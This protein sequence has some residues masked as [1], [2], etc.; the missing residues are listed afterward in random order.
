MGGFFKEKTAEALSL[1]NRGPLEFDSGKIKAEILEKYWDLGFYV[2]ENV[3]DAGEMQELREEFHKLLEKAPSGSASD[4]DSCGRPLE[5]DDEQ[6]RMF[7]FVKPLSD[8]YGGSDITG[9]RYQVKLTEPKPPEDAPD[10]VLLQIGG[11]LQF[12]D[13]CVRIYGHPGLLSMAAAVNGDDFTPFTEV[14][15][16]KQPRI[17]AAVSWHQDGT[18]HWDNPDLDAGTHGFNYMLNLYETVAENSLW[19]VPGSHKDGKADIKSMLANSS[20]EHLDGA[21]PLLC[22]PGDVAIVS[23]QIVH[24]SFPNQS[25]QPRYTFV[26]GFHRRSSVRNIQAWQREPY[27]D[28]YLDRTSRL[29]PLAVDARKENQPEEEPFRYLPLDDEEQIRWE[30][31]ERDKILKHYHKRMIGI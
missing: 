20:S 21:L 29:I 4:H 2:F 3:I 19:V 15:W 27:T 17:G 18:T 1:G 6:R 25:D 5:W 11:I 30:S 22:K 26:F 8:P 23:R 9:S 16:L 14:I 7:R 13:P 31:P 10:E 24:G 28:A 12:L